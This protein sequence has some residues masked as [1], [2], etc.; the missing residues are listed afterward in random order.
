M[1]SPWS[2]RSYGSDGGR[3]QRSYSP[4]LGLSPMQ[5]AAIPTRTYTSASES[6]GGVMSANPEASCQEAR[7]VPDDAS[8]PFHQR[9][10]PNVDCAVCQEAFK[11]GEEMRR[12]PCLHQFHAACVDPWLA[13]HLRCPLCN[14]D[15]ARLLPN[16]PDDV[17]RRPYKHPDVRGS[18]RTTNS[19]RRCGL[20]C[21]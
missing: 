16:R 21:A 13:R 19:F 20:S 14:T 11:E 18:P 17:G 10:N 3:A 6:D 5:I 8:L 9:S 12:L 7:A 4:P 2:P 15:I 1:S